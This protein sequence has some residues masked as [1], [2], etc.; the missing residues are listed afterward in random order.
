MS[1]DSSS[2]ESDASIDDEGGKSTSG[3]SDNSTAGNSDRGA[4]TSPLAHRETR[5]VNYSKI[6]VLMVL[7]VATASVSVAVFKYTSNEEGNN[8]ETRV[9]IVA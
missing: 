2:P 6:V 1:D 4:T 3:T 8:F 5:L 9:S 7:A